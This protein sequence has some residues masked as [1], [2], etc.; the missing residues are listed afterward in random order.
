MGIT[1]SF[2]HGGLAVA[3]GCP[4]TAV[5]LFQPAS[6]LCDYFRRLRVMSVDAAAMAAIVTVCTSVKDSADKLPVC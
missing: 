2:T 1:E 4:H 3:A 6:E 5:W